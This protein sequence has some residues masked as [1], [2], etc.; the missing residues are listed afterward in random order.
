MGSYWLRLAKR[1]VRSGGSGGRAVGPGIV[2]CAA[3]LVVLAMM[4]LGGRRGASLVRAG[5][6]GLCRRA[7]GPTL[8]RCARSALGEAHRSHQC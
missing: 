3:F 6:S 5:L 2:G 4:L 1:S 7:A 8:S